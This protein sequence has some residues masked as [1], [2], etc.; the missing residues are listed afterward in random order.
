[1][2]FVCSNNLMKS[3]ILVSHPKP[4]ASLDK[5]VLIFYFASGCRSAVGYKR[6]TVMDSVKFEFNDL[7]LLYTKNDSEQKRF[8]SLAF[9][10]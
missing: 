2:L 1:M 3:I 7:I 4:N 9:F 6:V 10:I 8:V 5:I